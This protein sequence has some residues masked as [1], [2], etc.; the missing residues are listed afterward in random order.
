MMNKN[1]ETFVEIL[2]V[3]IFKCLAQ[4][5]L[6][7]ISVRC[8]LDVLQYTDIKIYQIFIALIYRKTSRSSFKVEVTFSSVDWHRR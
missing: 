7:P 3:H 2:T 8:A 6:C 1:P 5:F 4:L